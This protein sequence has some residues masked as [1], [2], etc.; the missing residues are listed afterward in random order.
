MLRERIKGNRSW[1]EV[2]PDLLRIVTGGRSKKR[3]REVRGKYQP[4][5]FI[6]IIVAHVNA[7]AR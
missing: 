3:A 1:H 7:R 5:S 2:R 4:E 6:D